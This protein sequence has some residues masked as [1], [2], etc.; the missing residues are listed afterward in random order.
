[1]ARMLF[2]L[3]AGMKRT[4]LVLS[5]LAT[6]G[7]ANAMVVDDFGGPNT[8]VQTS[9][10]TPMAYDS[11]AYAVVPGGMRYLGQG[12]QFGNLLS[13]AAITG[14]E[15]D[16]STP[17]NAVTTTALCYGNVTGD[18][19][20]ALFPNPDW[21]VN[22][23]SNNFSLSGDKIRFNFISNE[24]SLALRVVL[25]SEAGYTYYDTT[26]AGAQ[27]SPFIVDLT[28]ADIS[29]GSPTT[30][31]SFD[32]MYVRFTTSPSGDFAL[33]SIETVPEPATMSILGLGIA[34]LARRKRTK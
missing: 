16:V 6:V 3:S 24:Q 11:D 14:N 30:L 12:Y 1:M 32:T 34:A 27:Y 28:S 26:V 18:V 5:A 33:R 29:S 15:L 25:A 7:V 23:G 13:G 19:G 10:A 9:Q 4:L 8:F 2:R 17:S 20:S 31:A 21:Y 22:L